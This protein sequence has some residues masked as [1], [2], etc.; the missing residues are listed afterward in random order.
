M[1]R[2]V[3][4]SVLPVPDQPDF[5]LVTYDAKDPDTKFDR[6]CAARMR[7]RG[8]RAPEDDEEHDK[9]REQV[10]ALLAEPPMRVGV[11]PY[12]VG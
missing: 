7:R 12:A 1:A 4:R 5:G 3:Q 6:R 2:E 11:R 10:L 9:V 8:A